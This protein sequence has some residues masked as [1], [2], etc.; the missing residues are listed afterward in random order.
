V[1]VVLREMEG[2][3]FGKEK[4]KKESKANKK[5]SKKKKGDKR[6]RKENS[7]ANGSE[8]SIVHR[9]G[10]CVFHLFLFSFFFPSLPFPPFLEVWINFQIE[11]T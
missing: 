1:F 4:K 2:R 10:G 9:G 11:T 6:K 7:I 3:G 5:K 8:K